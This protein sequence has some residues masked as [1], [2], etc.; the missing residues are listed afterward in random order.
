MGRAR[1][2]GNGV[3]AWL[4]LRH[5]EAYERAWRMHAATGVPEAGP[6]RIRAQTSADLEAAVFDLM[7]WE[8]P[9]RVDGPGSPF[10]IGLAMVEAA[11]EPDALPIAPLVA[12][13]GGSIEG[14][15]LLDGRL[16]LKIECG[17]AAVQLLLRDADPFPEDGGIEIRHR[18]GLRMPHSVRRMLEFWEVAGLPAPRNGRG[19]GARIAHW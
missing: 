4:F 13:G 14:L 1:E 19:R 8:D 9:F 10:W 12:A 5:V 11:I 15:R 2:T 7:A 6:F 18:F 16:V 17:G 3:H